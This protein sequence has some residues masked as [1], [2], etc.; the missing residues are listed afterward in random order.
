MSAHQK[1]AY[2]VGNDYDIAQNSWVT[3]DVNDASSC[4]ESS[5]HEGCALQA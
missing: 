4:Q 5:D 3:P 2:I 1:R